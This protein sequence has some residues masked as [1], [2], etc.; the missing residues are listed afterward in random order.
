MINELIK[1]GVVKIDQPIKLHLGCGMVKLQGYVNIDYPPSEHTIQSSS[2]ADIFYNIL[3][4]DFPENSVDEIRLHHVFEHF[5]RVTALVQLCRWQTWLKIGGKLVIETPDIQRSALI[6][7]LPWFSYRQKQ[8]VL[9]HIFGSHESHWA[10]HYDGWYKAKFHHV[11]SQIG[12]DQFEYGK[13]SWHMLRNVTVEA[14]KSKKIN[15]IEKREIISNIL[16]DS[17]VDQ[18]ETELK[19]H[20]IWM[21]DFDQKISSF[22]C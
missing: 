4:L 20:E 3:E 21:K 9:R 18:S 15:L 11:L 19:M 8:V 7:V 16:K 13:S 2:A 12:F 14:K 6:L 1:M 5:D 17:M 22:G 10:M